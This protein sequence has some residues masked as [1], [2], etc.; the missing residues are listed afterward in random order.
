M[1]NTAH[2]EYS[3][4]DAISRIYRCG[5]CG[6]MFSKPMLLEDIAA[7]QLDSI[8]D[9]ELFHS[10]L[11]KN[12]H[13]HLI[14][15]REIRAV[16]KLLRRSTFSVLDVGCGTGWISALW[17]RAGA[18]VIGLEPSPVRAAYARDNYGLKV[19]SSSLE[20]L[21][22]RDTYDVVIMRHVLEHLPDPF[23][24]LGKISGL[25][26]AGGLLLIIVPNIDCIGRYLFETKWPWV[27]PAHCIFFN[28]R[29]LRSLAQRAGLE[30]VR[31]Y[32]TPSPLWYPAS[33]LRMV[34]GTER[35][36]SNLYHKL[37]VLALIPCA[38]IVGLGYLSGLSDNITLIAR[39]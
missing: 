21:D 27:L 19:Q 25:L 12:L 9:G 2:Y 16:K 8:G 29:S 26:K 34:P 11:M 35:M 23:A 15:N 17:K 31:S 3:H 22:P 1:V 36:R 24:A 7:R 20:D 28:P 39:K 30:P 38:P 4:D 33:F 14:V 32:Q 6:L 5:A 10:A 18:D 13:E 37:H